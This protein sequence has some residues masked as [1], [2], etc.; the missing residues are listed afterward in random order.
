MTGKQGRM[1]R[2]KYTDAWKSS[3]APK[4]LDWPMQSILCGYPFKRAERSHNL[5]YWTY[6]VGQVVGE[7]KSR[8]T[9]KSE[10]ERLLTEYVDAVERLNSVAVLE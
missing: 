10:M 7:M 8:T 5:D 2:T 4:P 3:G 6:S 1:L 9:V